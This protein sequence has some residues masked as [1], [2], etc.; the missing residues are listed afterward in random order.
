MSDHPI[1]VD[2][3]EEVDELDSD[4]FATDTETADGGVF[5]TPLE[6]P[7]VQ[8][9]TT[10]ELH[11]MIHQGEIDINPPYQREV[12]WPE[13]KQICLIDSI[14]RNFMIPPVIFAVTN[15][16]EDGS[17]VRTCLDGKQRLTSIQKFFD[18]QIPHRDSRNNKKYWYT[19][20]QTASKTELPMHYKKLFREKKVTVVEYHGLKAGTEREIFQRVQLGM[21]LTAA[22]KLQ[23]IS[24]PWAQW[25]T[26]LEARHVTH[27][28]GLAVQLVWDTTRARDFQNIAYM[29]YCCD[30]YPKETLPNAKN[31]EKWLSREDKPPKQFQ[32]DMDDVLRGLWVLATTSEYDAALKMPQ[33]ISP[34]EFIFIGVVLYVLRKHTYEVK[35]RAIFSLRTAIREEFKDIR[36]NSSVG[37]AMWMHI[38][39]LVARPNEPL[40]PNYA[41][42]PPAKR[43]RVA[44]DDQDDDE[45]RP[46]PIKSVGKAPKTRAKKA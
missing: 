15:D 1:K 17:E 28:D 2:P 30:N 14:F 36:N 31:L 10:E 42:L 32:Q 33:R 3:T 13:T 23:A 27:E 43:K 5:D 12:V 7:T 4:E 41:N 44:A 37:R 8:L 35:A 11:T 38:Q 40:K 25:I 46:V 21:P 19:A 29:V 6:P 22:E 16:E 34:V 26:Q 24:S 45:F 39:S 18:G 9:M 20:S